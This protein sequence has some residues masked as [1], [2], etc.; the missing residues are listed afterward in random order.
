MKKN[1]KKAATPKLKP[2]RDFKVGQ[3]WND[4]GEEYL[5]SH[6]E[7]ASVDIYW[8]AHSSSMNVGID[9]FVGDKYVRTLS[10]LELELM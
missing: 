5:I 7:E 1:S 9:R 8:I 10:S 4:E 2:V 6:I 3:V